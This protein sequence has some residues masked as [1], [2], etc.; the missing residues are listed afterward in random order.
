MNKSRWW[1]VLSLILVFAAGAAA[2]IF[3]EKWF[4]SKRFEARRAQPDRPPTLDRWA[5]DLGLTPEQK[6]KIR[7]IFQNN[8]DRMKALRGDF[9]KHLGEIRAQLKSEID[10]VLTPEQKQKLDAIIQKHIAEEKRLESQR[11]QRPHEPRS[12]ETPQK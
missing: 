3:A 12:S 8:E 9:Y 6:E 10:A 11:R 7:V 1:I 5:K 4:L 2:G